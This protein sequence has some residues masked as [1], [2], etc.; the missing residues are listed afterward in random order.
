ML[1]SS[2]R[3]QLRARQK[4]GKY[5][6]VKRIADGGFARVYKAK[7][8]IEGVDVALKIPHADLMTK[9]A[10]QWFRQEARVH[11]SLD[12][13]N[14][15]P[16][17]NAEIIDGLFV[18]AYPLGKKSLADRLRSR[19]ST[20]RLFDFALQM[21]EA[22][23]YAHAH[24]VVHCDLKPE[25]FILFEGDRLRLADFGVAR[26][27]RRTVPGSGSG[28]IG[29]IAPE[30]AMGKTSPRAD[31]FSLGVILW[32]MLTGEL[33]EWPFEWPPKGYERIRGKLH[34]DFVAM[35]R[36]SMEVDP[37]KRF[38]DAKQMLTT[39]KKLM[40]RVRR[41]LL[42]K[43]RNRIRTN[44]NTATLRDW[45]QIRFRQFERAFGKTLDLDHVCGHCEGPVSE[46][47]MFC[48]WCSHE[49]AFDGDDSTFPDA[50]PRCQRGR[51]LDWKYC[52][53]CY[54]KSFDEVSDRTYTDKR[55]E[56]ECPKC[57][58]PLMPFMRY[59]PGCRHK[60]HKKWLITGSRSH[61]GSCGQGVV[62]EFWDDCPWCGTQLTRE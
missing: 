28:T 27:A 8:T 22:V 43:R 50:C 31:V 45:K 35:L 48:P 3:K 59:C 46:S 18:I 1:Q 53:W 10:M 44:S 54:G 29:F 12:H 20:D 47:M 49:L 15:L 61:C 6:I 55:Y 37:K 24:G 52:A 23:A 2:S 19:I 16:V 7:D 56:S 14:I 33:P 39:F 58:H 34:P 25:N 51:K 41:Q 11:A 62:R 21:L 13:P 32:L 38:A 60:L 17:K 36:R 42:Q 40:P 5:R 26:V 30:Q 4:L 57:E 9:N